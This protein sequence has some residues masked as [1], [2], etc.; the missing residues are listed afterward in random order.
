MFY[1]S[2]TK[3]NDLVSSLFETSRPLHFWKTNRASRFP[4][5]ILLEEDD[6]LKSCCQ[7]TVIDCLSSSEQKRHRMYR[8]ERI[9]TRMQNVKIMKFKK[10]TRMT[11]E[12][13]VYKDS[14]CCLQNRIIPSLLLV[15][16]HKCCTVFVLEYEN[17]YWG[18]K[19]QGR[20]LRQHLVD[21]KW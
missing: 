6:I 5:T 18:K 13:Y 12:N 21:C 15:V 2:T 17:H 3:C 1:P 14:E 19:I 7:A 11:I 20:L 10:Y 9:I 8:S 16:N 4:L